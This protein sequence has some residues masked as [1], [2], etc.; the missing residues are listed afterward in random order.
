MLGFPEGGR[1]RRKQKHQQESDGGF[2][3]KRGG[4]IEP[5]ALRIFAAEEIH[6]ASV[7]AQDGNVG[8][9]E[10]IGFGQQM[11]PL[12]EADDMGLDWIMQFVKVG[13]GRRRDLVAAGPG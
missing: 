11:M 10:E 1:K 2:D 8:E 6:D 5:A 12:S 9:S 3:K 13:R 7:A 4:E